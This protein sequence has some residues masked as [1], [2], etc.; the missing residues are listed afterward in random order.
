MQPCEYN[1]V[2]LDINTEMP[3]AL[4]YAGQVFWFWMICFDSAWPWSAKEWRA[5]RDW[6][7]PDL[8]YMC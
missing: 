6:K 1:G 4:L 7:N 2:V 5:T 3:L 8:I